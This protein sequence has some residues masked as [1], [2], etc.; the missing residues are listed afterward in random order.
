MKGDADKVREELQKAETRI[1]EFFEKSLYASEL[2]GACKIE[3]LEN[4]S[5]RVSSLVKL[6]VE[7]ADKLEEAYGVKDLAMFRQE[8]IGHLADAVEEAADET[9][10]EIIIEDARSAAACE[11]WDALSALLDNIEEDYYP[12]VDV[13]DILAAHMQSAE[14]SIEV[15]VLSRYE[16]PEWKFQTIIRLNMNEPDY[17][18]AE[19]LAEA[20]KNPALDVTLASETRE[21]PKESLDAA[22]AQAFPKRFGAKPAPRMRM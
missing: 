6:T 8:A 12:D 20:G 11:D 14:L 21:T 3:E 4:G 22:M 7:N 19:K 2:C 16:E 17:L 1:R 15:D 5:F 10:D 9:G 18:P 13:N